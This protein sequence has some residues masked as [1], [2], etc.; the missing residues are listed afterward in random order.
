MGTRFMTR[1]DWDSLGVGGSQL[2]R[3]SPWAGTEP[4]GQ[5]QLWLLLLLLCPCHGH[6]SLPAP[7]K[8]H[9]GVT[10]LT[11]TCHLGLDLKHSQVLS[12]TIPSRAGL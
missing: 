9:T 11:A 4:L 12:R 7:G 8:W 6:S 10:A 5:E 1:R 2:S 3:G